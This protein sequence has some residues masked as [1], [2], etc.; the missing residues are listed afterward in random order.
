[1]GEVDAIPVASENL[2]NTI[3][4]L[5]KLFATYVIDIPEVT[6]ADNSTDLELS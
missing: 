6:I 4:E 3:C 2:I 5:R 1:M